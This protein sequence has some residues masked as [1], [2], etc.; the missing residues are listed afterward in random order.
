MFGFLA[1]GLTSFMIYTLVKN[2]LMGK[3]LSKEDQYNGSMELIIPVSAKSEF[4]IE[5]WLESV[6]KFNFV[7]GQL[8]VHLLID[9][10]HPL[11]N[12]W[13]E[14]KEKI[15][16]LQIHSF[17]MRPTHMEA[18]PW[19]LE[20]I[21]S[22]IESQ[23]VIIGDA[24]LVPTEHAF[25][26]S[27]KLCHDKQR[28]YLVL[29]Q[30]GKFNLLGQAVS[31]LNPTLAFASFYGPH[32]W[33]S[34]LMHPLIGIAQGWLVMP[35][36]SFKQLDFKLIRISRWKEA[37]SR[38]WEDKNIKFY[39]AFGEKH[40]LRFYPETFKD[41]TYQLRDKWDD[42]WNRK[43]K[44]GFGIFLA[45]ML[46]W[47]FPI[48]FFFSHPFQALASIMLLTLYRFFTKIVFQES[49]RAILLHPFAC[50]VWM[51]TFFWWLNGYLRSRYGSQAP[52]NT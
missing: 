51:G 23:V 52:M 47:S 25:L 16:Y 6:G 3:Q 41:L 21:S 17:P 14:L 39:L 44:T 42:L 37:I 38:Q 10:H 45:S 24:E 2:A 11:L 31:V 12:A 35:L 27:A 19:M 18:V 46:V 32:R 15:P 7:P 49:W 33:R 9:G 29:P 20:Q 13:Q 48:I 40:L 26:S 8:K 34:R 50:V 36:A 1:L 5:A 28:N 22:K 30:T 43:D 4:F